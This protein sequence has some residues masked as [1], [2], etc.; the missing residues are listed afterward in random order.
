MEKDEE[1]VRK[2][3]KVFETGKMEDLND[4]VDPDFVEHTPEMGFTSSKKGIEYVKDL[5]GTYRN[6]LSDLKIDIKQIVSGDNKVVVYSNFKGRN[7]GD[8]MDIP[9]TNKEVSFD[10]IDILQM[11]NGK[12]SDHWGI[13]DNLGLMMQ[14]G[15]LDEKSLHAHH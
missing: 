2:A 13:A 15:V 3:L 14:M 6:V 4:L 1:V 9:A 5:V 8:L 7:T 11:K 10:N 12:V